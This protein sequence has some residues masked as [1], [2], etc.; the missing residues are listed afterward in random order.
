MLRYF[1]MEPTT[2]P[3]YKTQRFWLVILCIALLLFSFPFF[4]LSG[5]PDTLESFVFL[6]TFSLGGGLYIFLANLLFGQLGVWMT[7]AIYLFS[8]AASVFYLVRRKRINPIGAC[9]LLLSFLLGMVYAYLL[10]SSL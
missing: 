2:L 8:V 7:L 3:I 5:M 6:L 10:A 9:I 4:F 1:Y